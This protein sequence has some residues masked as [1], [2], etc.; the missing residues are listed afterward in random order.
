M[1]APAASAAA[2]LVATGRVR[3]AGLV[4]LGFALHREDDR[5]DLRTA[6]L[7]KVRRPMLFVQ[8]SRDRLCDLEILGR[9]RREMKLPGALHVVEGGDHSFQLPESQ[10]HRQRAVLGRATAAVVEFVRRLTAGGPGAQA[11][12]VPAT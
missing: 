2:A 4:F 7:P 1:T 8:G 12:G 5:E 6:D 10:E 9:V 3:P 11:L